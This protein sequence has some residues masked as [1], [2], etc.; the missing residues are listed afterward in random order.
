MST[1]EELLSTAQGLV[2]GPRAEAYGSA[3][4]HFASVGKMWKEVLGVDVTA[5]QVTLCLVLLKVARAAGNPEMRD[6]W[7]DIA[8][9]SALGGEIGT[10]GHPQQASVVTPP[11]KQAV[12]TTTGHIE[13]MLPPE[14]IDEPLEE[15]K[16][17]RR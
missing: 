4:E 5:E 16:P 12:P 7:V 9:Y 1:R 10:M 17:K 6:N 2:T 15:P 3:P 8:G 14:P 11:P 13:I